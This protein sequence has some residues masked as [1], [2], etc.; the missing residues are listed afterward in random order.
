MSDYRL[1]IM[2]Q[3]QGADP[4]E[5]PVVEPI[6]EPTEPVVELT[7]ESIEPV[8]PNAPVEEPVTEPMVTKK[9]VDYK[10][11]L[12][13]NEQTILKY[14]QEKN[15]DYSKLDKAEVVRR[16]IQLENPEFSEEDIQG[17]LEEKYGVGLSKIQI[18]PNEMTDEEIADAKKYN[19]ELDK[20]ARALKKDSSEA[21]NYFEQLKG[22]IELPKFEMEEQVEPVNTF[23]PEDYIKAQEEQIA[24]DK[25][26]RW[27]PELKKGFEAVSSIKEKVSYIDNGVEV[28]LEVDYKLSDNEKAE[29]LGYLSDYIGHPTDSKYLNQDG[30]I[31][32]NRF[33]L[34]KSEEYNRKKIY[35][36]IAKE[37]AANARKEFVKNNLV[38]YS[39]EARTSVPAP[40]GSMTLESYWLN[41]K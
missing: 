13:S 28:D 18:D 29:I 11:F 34:D 25:Q 36:T 3:T 40:D 10:S 27:I 23:S 20:L 12:E 26:E 41:K 4:I 6:E 32:V 39:E 21:V 30:T 35:K 16:K 1:E 24:K 38:N 19:K 2:A 9:E 7:G 37:A 5:E 22:T 14:L 31:D 17:E 8:V 15:T 33:L